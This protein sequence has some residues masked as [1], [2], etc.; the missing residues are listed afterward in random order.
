MK[1]FASAL[2]L[3]AAAVSALP[4]ITRQGKFLYDESGTR[5]LLKGIAYQEA[6]TLAAESEA[7]AANGG[8]PEPDSYVDPLAQGDA[9]ARDLPYLQ[10]LGVNVVRVYSVNS[11]L[12][13]DACMAAFEGAGIY[14]I[15]DLALPLNGSINRADPS[16]NTDLLGL[17][18][19]TIT[20]FSKYNNVLAFNVGNEVVNLPTNTQVAPFVK[21]A[22][23]DTKAFLKSI[24]SKALVSYT[25]GD[26]PVSWRNALATYLSCES[27]DTSIDIYGL[28][29]Y[30]L[31][32]DVG[33]SGWQGT[34]NDFADLT[35][36]MYLSEY[37]CNTAGTRT[38]SEVP[39]LYSSPVSDE[40][41]GGIAF[42]YFPTTDAF[43]MITLS[44]DN[45]TVTVSTEFE[46]LV[47]QLSNATLPTTPAQSS[48]SNAASP[49]CPTQSADF[50][51]S[52]VLPPTPDLSVCQCLE[53]SAF[54]CVRR[55]VT[56]AQ[57]VI[58]GEQLNYGCS[59][60]GSDG[61]TA[62]C[63]TIAAD[64]ATGTYGALSFCAA[65]IK[66][67]YVYSA[68]YVFT[69]YNAEACDFAGNATINPDAPRSASEAS[70]VAQACLDKIPV[71]GVF[72]PSAV[73]SATSPAGTTGT[74]TG[75]AASGTSA[76]GNTG[77]ASSR[78]AGAG[79]ASL[80]AVALGVVAF[81]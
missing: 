79:F 29:N 18:T 49:S 59:L 44:A 70:T 60:L 19:T 35:I 51:A 80:V 17:Y 75:A 7:N 20:T 68:H 22:A 12:N 62:T 8:Y 55:A 48:V 64:G 27:D 69:N 58:V 33:L 9:C 46:N 65:D 66:L 73:P 72:T 81:A 1:F 21:A 26:G 16:W 15:I 78:V 53:E 61:S 4:A 50:N 54:S 77:G 5:F 25:S 74:T 76:S 38:W 3:S 63:T 71:G 42:S 32:G 57:P 52:T 11:S 34:L 24:S 2:L 39:I 14:T 47:S 36:P 6:G 10:S 45:T 28:N 43:G 30:E 37:G 31:C 13:H 41:S 23:R 56:A 40:W 67:S